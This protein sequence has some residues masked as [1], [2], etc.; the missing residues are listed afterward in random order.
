[1]SAIYIGDSVLCDS[2]LLFGIIS[3]GADAHPRQVLRAR[4]ET[5]LTG[6][7]VSRK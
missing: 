7:F 5:R 3:V 2:S 1:M 6:F 4:L